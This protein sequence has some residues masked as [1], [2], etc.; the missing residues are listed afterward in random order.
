MVDIRAGSVIVRE[1]IVPGMIGFLVKVIG[2]MVEGLG[3]LSP[4]GGGVGV[5]LIVLLLLL[6]LISSSPSDDEC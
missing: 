2:V 5:A 6:S 4:T 1:D 3:A